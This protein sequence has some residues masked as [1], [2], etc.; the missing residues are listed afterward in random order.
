MVKKLRVKQCERALKSAICG[1]DGS[2]EKLRAQQALIPFLV[3]AVQQCVGE[4]MPS[5]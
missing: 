2:A 4:H 5:S 3:P 1:R